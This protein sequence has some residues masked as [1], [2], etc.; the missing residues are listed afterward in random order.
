MTNAQPSDSFLHEA[1]K[2]GKSPGQISLDIDEAIASINQIMNQEIA[3]H[4]RDTPEE[5]WETSKLAVYCHDCR[6][7]V[8]A[9][10]SKVRGK[11]RAICGACN[12]RKISMGRE[13]AL[14]KFYHIEK[15]SK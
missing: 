4:L 5:Q 7:I 11:T 12:S 13:K 2:S 6:A 1:Q 3:Q 9:K 14:E 8:P 10:L 15:S